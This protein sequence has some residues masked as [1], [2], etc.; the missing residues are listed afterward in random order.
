[1]LTHRV[2]KF[3]MVHCVQRTRIEMPR[4]AWLAT[5]VASAWPAVAVL[6]RVFEPSLSIEVVSVVGTH[7]ISVASADMTGSIAELLWELL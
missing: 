1:M 5:C 6:S 4:P 7:A 2:I 3:G